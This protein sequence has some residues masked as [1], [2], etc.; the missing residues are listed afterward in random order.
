[1]TT[2]DTEFAM[3]GREL[4]ELCEGS[5]QAGSDLVLEMLTAAGVDPARIAHVR[6]VVQANRPTVEEFG[7]VLAK[8]RT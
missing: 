6:A 1:M 4:F 5:R 2:L 8:G 7:A 3:T